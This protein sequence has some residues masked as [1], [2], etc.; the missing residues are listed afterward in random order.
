MHLPRYAC[1]NYFVELLD[2][3][4]TRSHSDTWQLRFGSKAAHSE[5][6]HSG[7][8]SSL[9]LFQ[10]DGTVLSAMARTA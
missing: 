7:H 10:T 1:I 3:C 2:P 6:L 9:V 5:N 4:G 8:M